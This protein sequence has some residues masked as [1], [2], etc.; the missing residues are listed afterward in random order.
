MRRDN[1]TVRDG[2][3]FFPCFCSLA[4]TFVVVILYR[5]IHE[6][7][8]LEKASSWNL[9]NKSSVEGQG[10]YLY[11]ILAVRS[12]SDHDV[13]ALKLES[14]HALVQ[15]VRSSIHPSGFTTRIRVSVSYHNPKYNP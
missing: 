2:V 7:P 9:L 11:C 10:W 15:Q 8:K 3:S 1:T 12:L 5:A 4:L 14:H 13:T 6:K